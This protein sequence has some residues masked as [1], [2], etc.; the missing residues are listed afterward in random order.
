MWRTG[1][2]VNE[3]YFFRIVQPGD[4]QAANVQS[5][6][7]SPDDGQGVRPGDDR[8]RYHECKYSWCSA[9]GSVVGSAFWLLREVKAPTPEQRE[10]I[11]RLAV[12]RDGKLLLQYLQQCQEQTVTQMVSDEDAHRVRAYQGEL[13]ALR[14]LLTLVTEPLK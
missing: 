5:N 3:N 8:A 2:D 13:R 4:P 9:E 7:G 10:A 14:Y 11:E 12:N 1:E 6:Q